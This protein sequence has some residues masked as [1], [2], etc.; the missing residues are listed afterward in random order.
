[1]CLCLGPFWVF[2]SLYLPSA[3][4]VLTQHSHAP[5]Q[6][7]EGRAG[8][9]GGAEAGSSA[10]PASTDL[11]ELSGLGVLRLLVLEAGIDRSP[12]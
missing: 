11:E 12:T 5:G 1:M 4:A 10:S 6:K 7:E 3:R 9:E 2:L 8:A